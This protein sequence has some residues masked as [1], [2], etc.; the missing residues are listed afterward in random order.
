MKKLMVIAAMFLI[1]GIASADEVR[2]RPEV[3]ARVTGDSLGL[4]F[5]ASVSGILQNVAYVDMKYVVM[6]SDKIDNKLQLGAGISILD[7]FAAAN[8][9]I[10]APKNIF[11]RIGYG[12]DFIDNLNTQYVASFGYRF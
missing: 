3:D 2:I 5:G 4:A 9:A 11:L 12:V 8:K 1:I 6:T 7:A 10:E